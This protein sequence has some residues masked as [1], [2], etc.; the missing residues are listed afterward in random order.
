MWEKYYSNDH[1]KEVLRAIYQ[2]KVGELLPEVL[3]VVSKVVISLKD[4]KELTDEECRTILGT[5]TLKSLID[6]S[7]RIKGDTEIHLAFERLLND[8][9]G[10]GDESAAVILDEYRLH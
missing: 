10:L 5:M 3:P 8:L 1:E 2:M 9:I 6:F 7:D 4:K